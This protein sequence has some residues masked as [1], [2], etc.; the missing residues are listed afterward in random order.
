MLNHS[1]TTGPMTAAQ[2]AAMMAILEE[3]RDYPMTPP[4]LA[5]AA[6]LARLEA[7]Q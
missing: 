4:V 1:I 7:Q 2:L 6:R 5:L 3:Y